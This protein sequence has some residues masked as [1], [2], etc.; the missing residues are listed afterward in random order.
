MRCS[1]QLFSVGW[2]S[3][4]VMAAEMRKGDFCRLGVKSSVVSPVKS[5]KPLQ[6]LAILSDY[7]DYKGD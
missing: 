4:R 2:T 5:G 6:A 1:C 3:E 7:R